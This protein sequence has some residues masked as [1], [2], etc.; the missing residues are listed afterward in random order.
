[1]NRTDLAAFFDLVL[2]TADDHEG[3]TDL[4]AAIA[5]RDDDIGG[6][7]D[8]LGALRDSMGDDDCISRVKARECGFTHRDL[9]QLLEAGILAAVDETDHGF[10][11][12]FTPLGSLP[13]ALGMVA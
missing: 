12:R 4:L 9:I 2:A 10:R 7:A 8:A 11:V 6:L 1:M 5:T 3:W 13:L